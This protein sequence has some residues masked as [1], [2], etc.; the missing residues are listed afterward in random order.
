MDELRVESL[1]LKHLDAVM[2]LEQLCFPDPWK[3]ETYKY[4][5]GKNDLSH[6]YG[7]FYGESLVAFGGFWQVLDEGHV[8]NVAVHPGFWRQGLGR[9]LVTHLITA[10]MGLGGQVMTLEVRKSN[11]AAIALYEKMGFASG[12][13]R[14][15][16]YDGQEDA[17]IMWKELY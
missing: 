1:S 4:E 17:V 2:L 3:R 9:L 7:C 6:Y 14:P 12:G 13:I 10:C 11:A 5:L 8:V 15:L 16:Y